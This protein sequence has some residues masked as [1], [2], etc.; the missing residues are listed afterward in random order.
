MSANTR[1]IHGIG[2]VRVTLISLQELKSGS[3]F[4]LIFFFFFAF[5]QRINGSQNISEIPFLPFLYTPSEVKLLI[6]GGFKNCDWSSSDLMAI[7]R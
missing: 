3:V 7:T 1:L 6:L 2:T 5:N 4:I